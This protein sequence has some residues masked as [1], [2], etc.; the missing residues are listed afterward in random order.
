MQ[1]DDRLME[2][3][4][5]KMKSS[6][7]ENH[8][9]F[10]LNPQ[11]IT[12]CLNMQIPEDFEY[13]D[14]DELSNKINDKLTEFSNKMIDDQKD[15]EKVYGDK[16]KTFN[17]N[18]KEYECIEKDIFFDVMEKYGVTLEEEIKNKIY[19]FFIVDEPTCTN[20]GKTM[21]MDFSKLKTLFT[22]GSISG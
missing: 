18:D 3:L 14:I 15:L 7:P 12:E 9:I 20:D 5:Y 1:L 17:V 13:H 11:I 22:T 16:V 8:S 2:Y 19:E 21:M 6:V 4:F 10:D